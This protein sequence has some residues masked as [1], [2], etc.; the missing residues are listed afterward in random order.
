VVHKGR[1]RDKFV[2]IKKI[3]SD[4]ERKAFVVELHQLSRVD[5]P[6]IVRLYGSC[7]SPV[8]LVMEYAEGEFLKV[9]I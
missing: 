6:N 1:W 5:H 8:C 9:Y 3:E 4:A 2:A 7:V